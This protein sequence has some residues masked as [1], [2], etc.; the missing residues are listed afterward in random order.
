MKTFLMPVIAVAALAT[1]T[2][3]MAHHGRG[4]H[5]LHGLRAHVEH[6]RMHRSLLARVSG[7]GASLTASPAALTGSIS[8]SDVLGTGTFAATVTTDWASAKTHSGSRGTLACAPASAALTLAG[9]TAT[10]TLTGTL[11]G[12]TCK[13]TPTNGSTVAAFFGRGSATGAGAAATVTGQTAK[14]FLVQRSDNGV[15]GAVFAGSHDERS[16]SLFAAGERSAA[17]RAGNCGGR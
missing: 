1:P 15:H 8:K 12:K 6:V 14:L 10:N 2:A 4:H 13:W 11:T 17:H 9:A 3:A 16:L 5:G 7:T